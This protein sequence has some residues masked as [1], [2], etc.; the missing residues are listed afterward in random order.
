M[1]ETAALQQMA[2]QMGFSQNDYGRKTSSHV[3][4][5]IQ[6]QRGKEP[7][8]STDKRYDCSH[9]CEWGDDCRKLRAVWLR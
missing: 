7:C 9:P 1:K 5:K 4:R 2:K 3:V 8:F 6:M